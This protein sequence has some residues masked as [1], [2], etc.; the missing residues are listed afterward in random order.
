MSCSCCF[1]K[2]SSA[3]FALNSISIFCLFHSSLVWSRNLTSSILFHLGPK[4]KWLSFPFWYFLSLFNS[5]NF[6]LY[7]L[8]LLHQ[9][10]LLTIN[11][12]MFLWV[13]LLSF[14]L[15]NLFTIFLML[16]NTIWIKFSAT[17]HSAHFQFWWIIFNNISLILSVYFFNAF[18]FT[19]VVKLVMLP[20]LINWL[21]LWFF[22]CSR[23][24]W[25]SWFSIWIVILIE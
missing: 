9:L 21:S 16:C 1:V 11:K 13:K 2:F 10:I 19:I 23:N 22:R 6:F 20:S 15:E 17:S 3:K 8:T 12:S 25:T 4:G 24:I 5:F 14:F 18:L 7:S